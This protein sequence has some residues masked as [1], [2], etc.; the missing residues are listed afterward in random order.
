MSKTKV[1]ELEVVIATLLF[2]RPY[3]VLGLYIA[4]SNPLRVNVRNCLKKLLDYYCCLLFL[5]AL[6]LVKLEGDLS[7]KLHPGAI[8][9]H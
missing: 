5:V 4:M 3:D 8:L 2:P 1:D 7:E 6:A 9:H